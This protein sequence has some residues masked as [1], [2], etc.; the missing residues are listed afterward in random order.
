MYL[1]INIFTTC[2]CLNIFFLWLEFIK[3]NIFSWLYT[4]DHLQ[5][6][7]ISCFFCKILSYKDI[8][9]VLSRIKY[10]FIFLSSHIVKKLL[11]QFQNKLKSPSDA[12][13]CNGH[14]SPKTINDERKER[15]KE[16][17]D[18]EASNKK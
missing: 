1:F 4:T 3:T 13:R 5:D 11:L 17:G 18:R 8:N 7:L 10:T 9:Q 2:L 14:G 16:V 15:L 12:S 6:I